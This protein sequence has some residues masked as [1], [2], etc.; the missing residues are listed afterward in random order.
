MRFKELKSILHSNRERIQWA[1]V[2][3]WAN[4]KDLFRGSVKCAVENYGNYN[5][6]RIY[7]CYENAQDCLVIEV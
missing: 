4:D 1:I 7:S 2:Y 5:V 3:D 6:R